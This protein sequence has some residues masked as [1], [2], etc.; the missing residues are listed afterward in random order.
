MEVVTEGPADTTIHLTAGCPGV[1][2]MMLILPQFTGRSLDRH[3]L[4]LGKF[5]R[6]IDHHAWHPGSCEPENELENGAALK[7]DNSVATVSL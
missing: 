2:I 1:L 5:F 7:D 6:N 4:P 3:N